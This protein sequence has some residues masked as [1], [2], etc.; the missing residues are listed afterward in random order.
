VLQLENGQFQASL[1]FALP[2]SDATL[3]TDNPFQATAPLCNGTFGVVGAAGAGRTV[4]GKRGAWT[5]AGVNQTADGDPAAAWY[6][7]YVLLDLTDVTAVKQDPNPVYIYNDPTFGLTFQWGDGNNAK[8][9]GYVTYNNN[10]LQCPDEDDDTTQYAMQFIAPQ[11]GAAEIN[12]TVTTQGVVSLYKGYW[13][14][15]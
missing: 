11:A 4:N 15:R 12:L 13:V 7:Q 3:D 9:G 10:V 5:R 2:V 6:G 8:Y 1:G 14:D